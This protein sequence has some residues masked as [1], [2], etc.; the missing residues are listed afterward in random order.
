MNL[1]PPTTEGNTTMSASATRKAR[2]AQAAAA[3]TETKTCEVCHIPGDDKT[4]ENWGEYSPYYMCI[5]TP[6]RECD[7]RAGIVRDEAQ[8]EDEAQ[9]VEAVAEETAEVS[10]A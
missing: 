6:T 3:V 5:E 8:A 7:K 9:A 4:L 1:I 2:R 10:Q